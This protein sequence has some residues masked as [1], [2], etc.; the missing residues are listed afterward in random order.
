MTIAIVW[1]R[2][3]LRLSDNPALSEAINAGHTPVPLYIHNDNETSWA[4]GAA[5]RWWLHHSL[6][7]L[8][9]SLQTHGS[10]LL[11]IEGDPRNIVPLTAEQYG[12]AAVYWNRCYDIAAIK[13]DTSIKQTL[14]DSGI[15]VKSF[16]A[17][18][19]LEP[20]QHLKK[21]QTPYRVFTPF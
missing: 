17:S 8:R 9:D 20:W 1:L 11:I 6:A 2:R 4:D 5:S 10:D 21:D 15:E 12:A 7:S 16:N 13:R 18:L 14:Q 19:L 3:D